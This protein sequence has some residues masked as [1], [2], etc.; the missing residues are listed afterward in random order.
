MPQLNSCSVTQQLIAEIEGMCCGQLL[1]VPALP[2][3]VLGIIFV[4]ENDSTQLLEQFLCPGMNSHLLRMGRGRDY[5]L[6]MRGMGHFSLGADL[7]AAI[8][9][10]M[11][12]HAGRVGGS[13]SDG[14]DLGSDST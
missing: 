5:K 2:S 14:H 9:M 10:E 8:S 7:F 4:T 6:C 13:L 12:R 11:F 3:I 1:G